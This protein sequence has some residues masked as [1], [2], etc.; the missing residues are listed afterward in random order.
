ML[1]LLATAFAAPPTAMAASG[2]NLA[3]EVYRKNAKAWPSAYVRITARGNGPFMYAHLEPHDD[4]GYTTRAVGLS[5]GSAGTSMTVDLSKGKRLV[6]GVSGSLT[7]WVNE[8]Y[9]GVR[10]IRTGFRWV[11]PDPKDRRDAAGVKYEEFTRATVPSGRYG[12]VVFAAVPC[13]GGV[14]TWQLRTDAQA[15][16]TLPN[17]CTS[18]ETRFAETREGSQCIL[19]GHVIGHSDWPY[20]FVV[21]DLPPG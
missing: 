8:Q 19:E 17:V 13:S 3:Y 7:F 1:A 20:R 2:S 10:R 12:S 9:W 4:G 6:L 18:E 15:P 11:A 21:L 14:G 16:S 5:A